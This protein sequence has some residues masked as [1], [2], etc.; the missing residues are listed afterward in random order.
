MREVNFKSA[1]IN[2]VANLL[3]V[4]TQFDMLKDH[5]RAWALSINT[6]FR[7]AW[8]FWDWPELI[9][10]EERAY[11]QVWY[12]DVAYPRAQGENSEFY[13]IANEK[14]YRAKSPSIGDPPIGTLPTN[15]TY[16]EEILFSDL[17][18]HIAYEQHGKQ[19]I[20]Q[21]YGIYASS[22]RLNIP[23]LKWS[24][25]PGGYGI[26]LP[27]YTGKTVWMMY[28]PRPQQ[29]T[30]ST[31]SATVTYSRGDVVLDLDS[32]DCYVALLASTGHPVTETGYWLRQQFPYIF[33]EYV[34][35]A[36]TS[37]Q[38]DDL[39]TRDRWLN[40]ANDF[41]YREVDKL[42]EQGEVHRY[43]TGRNPQRYPLGLSDYMLT[44]WQTT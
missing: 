44:Y 6:A 23:A 13:Y 12:N 14:Y 17:D 21:I 36:V 5:A 43:Q 30:S 24:Q 32:G 33:S 4:D 42:M 38:C 27:H 28:K 29:F 11:R 2:G 15:A 31:Y 7:Y 19:D 40:Q 9:V 41:L 10:T 37:E 22:P 26:D 25:M 1:I 39:Q 16:F 34:K 20:G 8:E 3:G 35:Y 18:R